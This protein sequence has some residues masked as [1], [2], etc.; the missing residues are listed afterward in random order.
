MTFRNGCF[1]HVPGLRLRRVPEINNCIVFKPGV[2]HLY[3][4]NLCAW[5]ILEL[6]PGKTDLELED[7]FLAMV[8]AVLPEDH[9]RRQL[10]DGVELLLSEG[11][12]ER[13]TLDCVAA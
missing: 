1:R 3:T 5:I 12:I 6:C 7:A 9:A 10:A 4:P 11:F 8:S 13:V 2:P